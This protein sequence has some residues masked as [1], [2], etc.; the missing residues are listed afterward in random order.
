MIGDTS[1]QN[2]LFGTVKVWIYEKLNVYEV[3]LR[4]LR[5]RVGLKAA[6]DS[7]R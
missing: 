4:V 3:S 7:G 5:R 1:R 6:E 2:G